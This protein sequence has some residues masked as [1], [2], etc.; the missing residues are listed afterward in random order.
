MI[1]SGYSARRLI[2]P[3]FPYRSPVS[4]AALVEQISRY[5]EQYG[6]RHLQTSLRS[7]TEFTFV[8]QR[9]LKS[10]VPEPHTLRL[11]VTSASSRR[12]S[13]CCSSSCTTSRFILSS[14]G[15][16]S[17]R[18]SGQGWTHGN[19][20]ALGPEAQFGRTPGQGETR[21]PSHRKYNPQIQCGFNDLPRTYR[22]PF[23][24]SP[25]LS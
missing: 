3:P 14:N 4:L 8:Y 21:P 18:H 22:I 23:R 20:H 5:G 9:R 2:A 10:F 15:S 16:P 6:Y 17:G 19:A 7:I 13:A 25:K 1:P 24:Y 11:S 12:P